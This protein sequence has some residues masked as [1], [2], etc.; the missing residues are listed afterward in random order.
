MRSVA[1]G[2]QVQRAP[3]REGR[4]AARLP[5]W[6]RALLRFPLLGK[7]A[8]ANAIIVVVVVAVAIATHAGSAGDRQMVVLLIGAL[9]IALAVNLLLVGVALQP[10]RE[11]E[12]TAERVWR[13]DL[14]A[15]VPQSAIADRDMERVGR[16]INLLLDCLVS[17]RQ[18]MRRLAAEVIR[19]GDRERARVAHELHDSTAQGLAAL[20]FQLSAMAHDSGEPQIAARLEMLKELASTVMEEVRLLA[21]DVYP[22]VLDN[23][24]LNAALQKLAREAGDGDAGLTIDVDADDSARGLSPGVA[25]VLYQ[26]AKEGVSNAMRHAAPR[27][28]GIKVAATAQSARLEVADDGN[29]FDLL[30]AEQPRRGMGLFAMRERLSLVDGELDIISHPG[31]GTRIIATVPLNTLHL[32]T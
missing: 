20:V 29:G 3:V 13:G 22:R 15:R 27:T 11:V 4:R 12:A 1:L 26:V 6:L 10:L 32:S 25:A 28:I 14:D 9:S 31:G 7:L 18:R 17:D 21:H 16:T 24:G 30:E 19:T 5:R 23:L 8:G 2:T